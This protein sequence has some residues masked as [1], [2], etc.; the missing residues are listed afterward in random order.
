MKKSRVRGLTLI[1]LMVTISVLVILIAVGVP[2]FESTLNSSRLSSSA[3]EL[4]GA[5]QLARAESIRR[6]RSVVLCRSETLAA[7]ASGD[8]W[9]GWLVFVDTNGDGGVSVGEEILKTGTISTPLS[10]R[11]SAAIS[12]RGHIVTFMPNGI[13]RAAD[14]S[15]LLNAALAICVASTQPAQ[16]TRELLI[17]FGGRTTVR[18]VATGGTCDAAPSDT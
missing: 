13:A 6:N 9:S 3:N 17:A 7:C 1:E 16:N 10:V 2:S 5:V 15:A 4:S 8:V 18:S 12:S 14:E 11:A